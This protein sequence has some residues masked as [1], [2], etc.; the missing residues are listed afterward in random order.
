[1]SKVSL[2]KIKNILSKPLDDLIFQAQT[3]H[4]KNFKSSSFQL[5]SL[6]SIKTGS[7]PEDCKYCP[8][9]AHY[10]V[11]LKKERLIEISKVERAAKVAKSNGADRFCMGAAWKK[12]RDGEDLN[13][14]IQMIKIVKSLGLEACVTLGSITK[15]Q[16]IALKQAGLDAYNHNIDT[17]PEYYSKIITTRS[18]NERLDTIKNVRDA[19]I[20]VCCGGIIG[21][22]ESWDDR[23]SMLQVLAN[24]SPQPE[25]VPINALVPVDG[26]PLQNQKPVEPIEMIRMVATARI[27]MPKSRIRLSAG[28]KKLSQETQILCMISGANSIFYGESLLTTQNND[29]NEDKKLISIFKEKD[30]SILSNKSF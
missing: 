8:Q 19:G 20:S 22:G 6:I 15:S 3:I 16:A 1:M 11:D 14:V 28:R 24:L 4:K 21:M 12:L 2:N 7:C 10:N 13:C 18:F 17:S 27:L 23:A 26:T 25:S 29:M 9:S 30:K 5:A